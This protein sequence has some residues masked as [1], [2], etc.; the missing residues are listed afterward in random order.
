MD[1]PCKVK[2]GEM[3]N[4]LHHLGNTATPQPWKKYIKPSSFD[5]ASNNMDNYLITHLL[6]S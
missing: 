5:L 2:L 1:Y 4:N 6:T 3:K